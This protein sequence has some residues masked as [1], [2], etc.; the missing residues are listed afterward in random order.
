VYEPVEYQHRSHGRT[1]YYGGSD[2]A[3]QAF[4]DAVSCARAA[5]RDG[6]RYYDADVGYTA[7]RKPFGV[8]D[9]KPVVYTDCLPLANAH[10]YG[11]HPRRPATRRT[12][13]PRGTSRRPACSERPSRS[14]AGRTSSPA[15]AARPR[16]EYEAHA[17]HHHDGPR[18]SPGLGD[19][20]P[21]ADARP[22]VSSLDNRV[23]SAR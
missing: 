5:I 4:A 1:Y 9:E 19:R 20:H 23:A 17:R 6:S 11:S 18:D 15:G 2:P 12:P 16:D 3:V 14:A 13:P 10:F 8:R 21:E 22:Q 7:V